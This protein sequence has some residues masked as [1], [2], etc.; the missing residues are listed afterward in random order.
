[1]AGTT[2][3]TVILDDDKHE[4]VMGS[5]KTILDGA[6][7]KELMLHT[8]VKVAFVQPVFVRLYQARL[9]WRM[10]MHFLMRSKTK[11]L[12]LLVFQNH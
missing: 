11:G 8:H 3:V 9:K 2:N 12:C 1:M 7:E 10:N 5:D 6:L 4:F